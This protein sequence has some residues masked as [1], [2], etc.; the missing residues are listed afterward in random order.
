MATFSEVILVIVVCVLILSFIILCSDYTSSAARHFLST[1]RTMY[2]SHN[3]TTNYRG[4][5]L[6][7]SATRFPQPR[8]SMATN[9]NF[10]LLSAQLVTSRLLQ[11][12]SPIAQNQNMFRQLVVAL[13]NEAEHD[14]PPDYNMV[15]FSK[16][17]PSYWE[18]QHM[19]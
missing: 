17:P 10:E 1:Q 11:Q 9:T 8:P 18:V 12:T 16:P 15:M 19:L 13:P 4:S 6:Q 3:L 2:S 7:Q 5:S 14:A